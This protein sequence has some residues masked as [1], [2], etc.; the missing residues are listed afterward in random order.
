MTYHNPSA[1]QY[2]EFLIKGGEL[3]FFIKAS[4]IEASGGFESAEGIAQSLWSGFELSPTIV[5]PRSFAEI[6]VYGQ[7][8]DQVVLSVY[9]RA[10]RIIYKRVNAEWY[11]AVCTIPSNVQDV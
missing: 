7:P 8:W 4:D 1:D 2:Q 3:I 10:G 6:R 5:T 9:T 11:Q